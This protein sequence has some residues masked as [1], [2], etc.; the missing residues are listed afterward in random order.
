MV[1]RDFGLSGSGFGLSGSD[2]FFIPALFL[3]S[4]IT[5]TIVFFSRF[6][7]ALFPLYFFSYFC[8]GFQCWQ[9][10]WLI[11]FLIFFRDLKNGV[12]Y[13][14][15]KKITFYGKNTFIYGINSF[16][17]IGRGRQLCPDN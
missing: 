1:N 7:P 14:L 11:P 12:I 4:L 16:K 9:K 13:I 3:L 6:I 15:I 5:R 10:C 2:P 17:N 8:A